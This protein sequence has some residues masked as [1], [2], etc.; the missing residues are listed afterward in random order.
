L[1]HTKAAAT[2]RSRVLAMMETT[3]RPDLGEGE[4]GEGRGSG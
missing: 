3:D 2:V 1:F 4:R